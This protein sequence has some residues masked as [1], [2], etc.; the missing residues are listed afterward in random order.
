MKSCAFRLQ[1]KDRVRLSRIDF[2]S[3]G[4]SSLALSLLSFPVQLP[5]LPASPFLFAD[6]EVLGH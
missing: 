6:L 5:L 3:C 4:L 1:D 2:L